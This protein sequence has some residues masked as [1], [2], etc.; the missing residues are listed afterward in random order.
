MFWLEEG[1]PASLRPGTRP[2]TTL[3]PSMATKDGT[4]LA[5]GSPGGDN[6]DQWIAQFFL[7]HTDHGLNLQ[8]AID[9][10]QM[11]SDHWPNSFYPRRA[12][13]AKIQMEGRFPEATVDE[14]KRR[15]HDVHLVGD[16]MLGRNCAASSDGKVMR[17]AATPR[18]QM[19]YAIGR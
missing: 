5:F 10:P 1:L 17:A 6:Q 9:A 4:T 18:F 7:R 16:W 15:G 13:P 8:A 3:T 14:L 11:Q 12:S 2:R 19:G